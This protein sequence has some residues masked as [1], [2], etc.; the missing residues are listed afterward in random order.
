MAADSSP[1]QEHG[2]TVVETLKSLIMAFVIAMTFRGFVTEGFVIPTGSMAP[3]LMGQHA[4]ID[5]EA[6]GYSFAA[7]MDQNQVRFPLEAV[8]DPMIGPG[9]GG[10][11]ISG[12]SNRRR[13]GDR[14]LVLKTIYPFFAPERFDVVVFKN[15]T[16]PMGDSA[17]YIKRL[18]GLP[19][20]KILLADGDVFAGPADDPE[21]LDDYQIQRKPEHV[22]RAVW[23]RVFDSDYIPDLNQARDRGCPGSPWVG[24]RWATDFTRVFRCDVADPTVL[25]WDHDT[26]SID[27]WTAYNQFSPPDRDYP[28]VSDIRV[29]AGVVPDQ[30]GLETTLALF[31]REHEIQFLLTG[32]E[33]VVRM[34]PLDGSADWTEDRRSVTLPG[35]GQV[36]SLEFWHVDQA[37]SIYIDRKRVAHLEYDWMPEERLR[38]AFALPDGE[39]VMR[40]N[41]D[42]PSPPLLQWRFQGSPVSLHRVTLDRDLYYRSATLRHENMRNPPAPGFEAQVVDNSWGFATHPS[43][44]AV[45]G[46]DHFFMLGDNSA[47]SLDGRL[48]GSPHPLVVEQID[49][50]PFVV[51][52]TLLIGKAWVVYFPS[53]FSV[54]EGGRRF[55]P[56]FGRMRFIR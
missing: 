23:Q 20:E 8:S 52:R 47:R 10:W 2:L 34:R 51:N 21:R 12:A 44:P 35:P 15:P 29:C 9:Y 13:M 19:H 31:A 54:T 27:D 11:G 1:S 56:D 7:G 32:D 6:T 41:R 36:F 14:I 53:P 48:W 40:M 16:E 49:P 38:R 45:L 55:V 28:Y 3:T 5:S 24:E 39:D 33:A 30:A 17:N 37:L 25:D 26:R 42:E 46:S 50:A 18:I 4:L 22:Q 43:K